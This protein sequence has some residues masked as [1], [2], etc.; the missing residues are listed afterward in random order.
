MTLGRIGCGAVAGVAA[1]LALAVPAAADTAGQVFKLKIGDGFTVSGTHIVCAAQVSKTLL[2]GKRLIGCAFSNSKGPLV[3]TYTVAL[4]AD[5]EVV[6]A[7]V[8]TDGS[9]GVVYRRKPSVAGGPAKLYTVKVNDVVLFTGTN[10]TCSVN[11]S[12][13]GTATSCFPFSPA[14]GNALPNTYGVG[15]TDKI[16]FV[17]H[18]DAK[19]KSTP[20]KVLQHEA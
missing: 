19:S 1:S 4:A 16:A 18:F 14:K 12:S 8:K 20:V 7:R 10:I 9:A 5:G 2:P 3:G 11:K 13:G 15:I 17:V 6:A